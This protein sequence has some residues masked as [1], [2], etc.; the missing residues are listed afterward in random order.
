MELL[1]V[2]PMASTPDVIDRLFAWE[3]VVRVTKAPRA[4]A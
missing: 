2:T 4:V 1:G 3:S